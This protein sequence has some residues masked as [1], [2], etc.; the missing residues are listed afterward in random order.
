MSRTETIKQCQQLLT[1]LKSTFEGTFSWSSPYPMSLTALTQIDHLNQ[2]LFDGTDS[3]PELAIQS[4]ML[5]IKQR[6][7]SIATTT[8]RDRYCLFGCND[9]HWQYERDFLQTQLEKLTS[10]MPTLLLEPD[11][12]INKSAVKLAIENLKVDAIHKKPLDQAVIAS[13]QLATGQDPAT[14]NDFCV[15]DPPEPPKRLTADQLIGQFMLAQHKTLPNMPYLHFT[16]STNMAPIAMEKR[17]D[18]AHKR[19]VLTAKDIDLELV[20][21]LLNLRRLDIGPSLPPHLANNE[22]LHALAT[23]HPIYLQAQYRS[24][25]TAMPARLILTSSA[26]IEELN[27]AAEHNPEQ[28]QITLRRMLTTPGELCLSQYFHAIPASSTLMSDESTDEE[29]DDEA[30]VPGC[31]ANT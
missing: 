28:V 29:T 27:Q 22:C 14:G 23:L 10:I 4:A 9:D 8:G 7:R 18:T 1:H 30:P 26:L 19:S 6:L 2:H 5:L 20:N 25:L 3:Q 24:L 31:P 15:I 11:S 12:N 13:I 21:Q 17:C 16:A